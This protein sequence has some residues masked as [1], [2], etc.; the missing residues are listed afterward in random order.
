MSIYF[1]DDSL[2]Q[3]CQVNTKPKFCKLYLSSVH[4]PEEYGTMP[5]LKVGPGAGP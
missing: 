3:L 2:V 5:F 4:Q 1:I